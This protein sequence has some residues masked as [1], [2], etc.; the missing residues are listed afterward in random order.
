MTN[1]V[2]VGEAWGREEELTKAPFVGA[3]GQELTRMLK[4]AGIERKDVGIT[5]VFNLRPSG[6]D[7][8][9]LCSSKSESGR[10]YP[11]PMLAPGHYVKP[12]YFSHLFALWEQLKEWQPNLIVPLGN[13]AMW[14]TLGLTG[15]KARRGAITTSK[16]PGL[17]NTKVLPTIHPAAVLRNWTDRV[18]VVADFLKAKRECAFPEVRVLNREIWLDPTIKDLWDF[19]EKYITDFISIDIE[20]AHGTVTC[21]S[22]SPTKDRSIVLPFVDKKRPGYSYW[23]FAGNEKMAWIWLRDLLENPSIKKLLQNGSYDLQYLYTKLKLKTMGYCQDTMLHHHSLQPEMP[24]SL[25]FMGSIY[26][27]EGSWKNMRLRGQK[28]DKKDE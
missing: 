18:V 14:A 4:D 25:G 21:I 27:N 8:L 10:N 26:T 12:E 15:I 17:E 7:V 13:T 5:N 22:I 19:Q 6:N 20:T 28:S 1:L 2:L 23:K 24:K 9:S 11:F 16:I 3:S